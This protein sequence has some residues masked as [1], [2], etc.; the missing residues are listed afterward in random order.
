MQLDSLEILH[1]SK[2]TIAINNQ[3]RRLRGYRLLEWN[4]VEK[5][6]QN[7]FKIKKKINAFAK[8]I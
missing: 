8:S 1:L 5:L 7:G 2:N 4:V 3:L 6:I